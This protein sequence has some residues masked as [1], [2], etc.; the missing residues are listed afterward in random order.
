MPHSIA[1][2]IES[3]KVQ[4]NGVVNIGAIIFVERDSQKGIVIGKQGALLKEVGKQA[5][6]DIEVLSRLTGISRALG[7]SEEG[8]AQSRACIEGSWV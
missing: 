2:A 1:V 3:M 6:R 4:E 8:L 7:Q 5:R